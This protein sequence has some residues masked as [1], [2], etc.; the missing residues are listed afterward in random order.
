MTFWGLLISTTSLLRSAS[1]LE[2]GSNLAQI[3]FLTPAVTCVSNNG[4]WI[5]VW[6]AKVRY[7]YQW[8]TAVPHEEIFIHIHGTLLIIDFQ[9]KNVPLFRQENDDNRK[10]V[11][12]S[13]RFTYSFTT[14]WQKNFNTVFHEIYN[15]S[16]NHFFLVFQSF[17]TEIWQKTWNRKC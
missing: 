9:A 1:F 7:L 6:W 4:T 13:I 15:F 8:A 2:D 3:S 12:F 5:Q 14:K 10:R 11:L 17:M 16:Y